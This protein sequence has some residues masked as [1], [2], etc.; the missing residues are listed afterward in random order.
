MS[1]AFLIGV[2]ASSILS[3]TSLLYA[4]LGEVIGERAGIVNLGLEGIMLIGAATGFAAAAWTGN[5]YLGLLAAALAGAATNLIFAY[6]VVGRRA[7]QLASGLSLMF[8]GFGLSALVGR[9]FV[10]ALVTGLPRLR[11][12]GFDGAS[13][14][15]VSYDILVWL[16]VPTALFAWALLFRTRW[17]LALRAVGESPAVAYAAGY[18]PALL[19]YQALALAGMLGGIAGAHLSIALTLTWAEGMTAGRGFI[20]IALVIFSRWNPLWAIAGALLFGGAEALQLQLQAAG[21]DVSPFL[22]N[23]IPYLLTLLVL[24]VWGMNRQSAAPAALGRTLV[25]VE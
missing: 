6:L 4:T 5:P 22:M 7:N 17:G 24:I 16:A 10:G 20:A 12:P 1:T 13:A 21:A 18:R 11:L 3:G 19:Q 2:L 25:G 15:L 9:P 14:R 23:M 8:F